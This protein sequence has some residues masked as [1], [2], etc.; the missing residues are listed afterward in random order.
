MDQGK[1]NIIIGCMFSGKS[2][3]MIRLIK[4]YKQIQKY[5]LLIINSAKDNRYGESVISSHDKV[6]IK[7]H[8]LNNLYDIKD[9][10]NYKNSNV[11][12]IEEGQFFKDLLNFCVEA[13]DKDNKIIYVSGLDGDFQKNEFGQIC[14]LIPHAEEVKKL[15]ALCNK[16]G[17][18]TEACFTKR[19]VNDSNQELIGSTDSYIPVC[20]KHFKE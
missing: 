3:E 19:I 20:R 9:T 14:K 15:K 17:D 6:Q 2:T 18:G 5:K 1:I 10:E 11:I 7:C 16:C 13:A 4:R 12:F 8:A